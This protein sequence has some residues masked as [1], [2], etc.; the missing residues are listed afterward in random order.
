MRIMVLVLLVY[1]SIVD[2]KRRQVNI[3]PMA[4]AGAVGIF[5]NYLFYERGIV[6]L[7]AGAGLGMLLLVLCFLSRQRIGYGDGLLFVTLGLCLGAA[8]CLWLIWTSMI[9]AAFA[10]CVSALRKKQNLKV[11]IPY[12]PFVTVCFLAMLPFKL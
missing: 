5:V 11:A 1:E 6:W 7:A 10:G 3:I 9:A 8:E 12:L 2:M 4:L